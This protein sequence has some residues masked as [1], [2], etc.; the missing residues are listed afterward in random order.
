MLGSKRAARQVP[1]ILQSE[2]SE[3][4]LA[5]V[6]MVSAAYGG[7]VE[8]RTLRN[9]FG[10][11]SRGLTLRDVVQLSVALDLAARPVTLDLPALSKMTLPC[12]LHWKFNHFVT[13]V[14]VRGD[15]AVIHDPATGRR[16]VGNEELSRS[17]T[18]V[19]IELI[20]TTSFKPRKKTQPVS[21]DR[22]IGERRTYVRP[23]LH[24]VL[25][26][27][28]I[29]VLVLLLPM[30]LQLALDRVADGGG[31]T[32]IS[33]LCLALLGLVIVQSV[34][35]LARGLVISYLGNALHYRM[36]LNLFRHLMKLPS[37]FFA[38]RSLADVISRFDS[39]RYI[40]RLLSQGF[41]EAA[42]DGVMVVMTLL[43]LFMYNPGLTA[44]IVCGVALYVVIRGV[45]YNWM[46]RCQ[47][48]VIVN[49][50]S[51]QSN[52]METVRGIVAVK[53]A[54]RTHVREASWNNLV[55]SALKSTHQ[56][57]RGLAFVASA[58]GLITGLLWVATIAM[59]S[60]A[61]GRGA[62]TLGMVAAFIAWQQLAVGRAIQ[63]TDKVFEFRMLHL[64]RARVA[65][66]S[67]ETAEPDVLTLGSAER[68]K[69]LIEFN[70]VS[71]R[72]DD[73]SPWILRRASM[74]VRPGDFIAIVAPSG[75]GKTT[76][77]KLILGLLKP[78][79][80]E[81]CVDGQELQK[82]GLG[83]FRE[84]VGVVMQD[85]MLFAGSIADNIAFFEPSMDFEEV[86]AAARSAS[87]H[88]DIVGMPMGYR[89]LV[90][91]M[92]S[93]LSGGQRQRILLARAL[94]R[95][96]SVLVLDEATS[97]LDP[98]RESQVN[99][100][101]GSLKLTRIIVAHRQETIA[102]ASRVVRLIDG[103]L[104]EEPALPGRPAMASADTELAGGVQQ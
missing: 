60:A 44:I 89:T 63:L 85:D 19:A 59:T 40:Q 32:F 33:V 81:V 8:L 20:P 78:T 76:L 95:Q 75:K 28:A 97:H 79:N 23:L 104:M 52:F 100:A 27:A 51:F 13:L 16:I 69:G 57:N 68:V 64:H 12:I 46:Y 49:T 55:V 30:G 103:Q 31:G 82:F 42:V 92:G 2:N 88:E 84:S 94:Y 39:L 10:M 80:G 91:D 90:G 48:D 56:S 93:A 22:L 50:A 70:N 37:A 77:I 53:L 9:T 86:Q 11:S 61:V 45:L 7:N 18:G 17:F 41:L 5:C 74:V 62:M 87:V 66:I 36:M 25:L 1:V 6:A 34:I 73:S 83:T 102:A 98:F 67:E 43:I 14:E 26:S 21:F 58:S 71:F 15:G 72:Y 101:V 96:P 29:Q 24:A 3:C 99:A 54:N 38:N 4:A 65:D 35:T 47:Q